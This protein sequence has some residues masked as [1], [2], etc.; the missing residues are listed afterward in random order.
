M[1]FSERSFTF[2]GQLERNNNKPWFEAHRDEY[3][4]HIREP[5]LGFIDDVAEWFEAEGLPY[6]AEAKKVGGSLGRI[7][8]DVP[9]TAS[10]RRMQP[11]LVFVEDALSL[12]SPR[13]L[14]LAC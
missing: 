1:P 4:T 11:F 3:E 6:R 5:A 10:V 13:A 8:R 7:H 9:M 2:L 14:R 12:R